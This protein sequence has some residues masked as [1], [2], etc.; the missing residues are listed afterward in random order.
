MG[1]K[2][3][4]GKCEYFISKKITDK[5]ICKHPNAIEKRDNYR[6]KTEVKISPSIKNYSNE[7]KDF[8]PRNE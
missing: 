7:C 2:V 8:K 1:K 6:E 5:E 4:C 3:Y